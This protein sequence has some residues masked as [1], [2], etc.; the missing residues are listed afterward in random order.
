MLHAVG[1]GAQNESRSR[2][3]SRQVYELRNQCVHFR[4][5]HADGNMLAVANWPTL[6]D[7]MLEAVQCLY[8]KYTAAFK[9]PEE[10]DV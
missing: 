1:A 5:A 6:S 2:P 4:P 9:K 7:L 8:A 3:V 10:I